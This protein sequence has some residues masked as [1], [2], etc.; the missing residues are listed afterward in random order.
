MVCWPSARLIRPTAGL[1]LTRPWGVL[2]VETLG[3]TGRACART[4]IGTA[5]VLL[6][7]GSGKGAIFGAEPGKDDKEEEFD[8]RVYLDTDEDATG[9]LRAA[10]RARN[11]EPPNWR[12]AIDKYLEC[13]RSYGRT[14]YAQSERLYLP[15][16][17]LVR[18]ELSELPKEGQELYKVLKN[19]EAN[20]AYRRALSATSRRDLEKV[21][22]NYPCL[23]AAPRSLYL[24]G[25]LFRARG[26]AGRA[27]YYWQRLMNDYPDWSECN[28]AAL[29]A[30][31][32]LVAAEAGRHAEC[33]RLLARLKKTSGLA[34]LRVGSREVLVADEVGRRLKAAGQV[35]DPGKAQP[36]FWPSVGGSSAHDGAVSR[37]V[38]AGVRRWQKPL[39]GTAKKP[40][41]RFR[42]SVY[43]RN[44]KPTAAFSQRH[45]VCAGGMIFLAGDSDL[46]AV[47]AM[48]GHI[49]WPAAKNRAPN[50]RLPSTRMTLP[51]IGDGKVFAVL[52]TPQRVNPYNF[53][54]QGTPKS[55]VT[56]RAYALTS[57][58]LRWE[59]G[60]LE[61]AKTREFLRSVDLVSAPVYSGG[62]VFCPAV[63]RGSVNDSYV[64]CF[65]AAD[66]RLVWQTFVC[67]GRPVR[68]GSSYRAYS[69]TEDALPPAVSEGLV[70]FASNL[71]AIGVMDAAS[72]DL[73]WVYLY[74]RAEAQGRRN[75]FG[76]QTTSTVET[77]EPSAPIVRD[78]M[79][80]AAPQD[81]THLFAMELS[82]G[83]MIWRSRRG[84][85]KRLV[86][87]SD[88]KLVCSGGSEIMAFSA[89][90]GK[91]LWRGLL[92][93]TEQGMGLVGDGFVVIPSSTG[94]QR[95]DLETGKL[96]A[97]Y[98]FRTGSTESGN[99]I[100]SGDVLVSAGKT[101]VGGYY[102]W[103]EIVT[104]L[105]KQIVASPQAAAPRAELAEVHFSAEKY[106]QASAYFKESLARVK[107]DESVAGMRLKPVLLRQI[108]ESHSRLAKALEG[109]GKHAEALTDYR[110][111]HSYSLMD[112]VRMNRELMRGHLRF[113]RCK[114][115]LSDWAGAV[116]EYQECIYT[117]ASYDA[118]KGISRYYEEKHSGRAGSSAMAGPFAK[119]QID[120]VIKSK[121]EQAYAQFETQASELLAGAAKAGS[122]K[123]AAAV[124]SRYPNSRSLSPALILM[125]ELYAT[126]GKHPEA[127]ARL[128]EHLSRRSKSPRELEVR[129]RLALS[130]KNQGMTSLTRSIMG[131]MKRSWKGKSFSIAGKEWTVEDFVAKHK[132][133]GK[134]A[135]GGDLL[136]ELGSSLKTAWQVNLGGSVK[137]VP[138]AGPH[139]LTGTA[140]VRQ[141][142]RDV[143]AIDLRTGKRLWTA[144]SLADLSTYSP[145][146]NA[147]AGA[148][149]VAVATG[150]KLVGLGP[151]SGRRLWEHKLVDVKPGNANARFGRTNYQQCLLVSGEGVV[152]AA[153]VVSGRDPKTGRYGHMG[154]LV[155]L[156]EST[157]KLLWGTKMKPVTFGA[158]QL[159]EGT[160][161]A[162]QC[163]RTRNRT[164]VEAY[165][166]GDGTV[167]FKA[168]I[169]GISNV[170]PI[171]MRVRGDRLVFISRSAV[172]CFDTATGKLKWK[173]SISGS[174]QSC[175]VAIDDAR[176]VVASS[177]YG[178]G[179]QSSQLL[180]WSLETGKM[181]WR[182]DPIEG[183]VQQLNHQFRRMGLMA[184]PLSNTA[185]V[186]LTVQAYNRATRKRTNS[187]YV[188]DGKTG[189]LVWRLSAGANTAPS[190][191]L[192]GRKYAA[193]LTNNRGRSERR[194]YDLK[195]GKLVE[196]AAGIFGY[197]T[198]QEG[199]ILQVSSMSLKKL[200]PAKKEGQRR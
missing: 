173:N 195:T 92:S 5:L 27:V 97:S 167:R 170:Y 161:Y 73:L 90:S 109:S 177:R 54:N 16:R 65:D 15:V 72:G 155:V 71:G 85:L 61:D 28:G 96:K 57:G 143:L 172:N 183:Y 70:V 20:L 18:K 174:Q 53:R 193:T 113:A 176:V 14:V 180:C 40:T 153:P 49:V 130:Y 141:K 45:P 60:R 159:A 140:F 148:G 26:Q 134:L 106:R 34:R 165:E 164:I 81:S 108:W 169:A 21:P 127:A 185:H 12:V 69:A 43:S 24:L 2:A 98:R 128:R 186:A 200:K 51:A 66:G 29:L 150:N 184:K 62:Y 87:L 171:P 139:D 182:T 79:I 105:R 48:S 102:S 86:G 63:K 22:A 41:S 194:I 119:A 88:G 154:K 114:E 77:W 137:L 104:K 3:I 144:R 125:S 162:A 83:R 64:L 76:R 89:R 188:Y 166:I 138:K 47:R 179:K 115:G 7:L 67:A 101:V 8:P 111:A 38:D 147:V 23:D 95:F 55:D 39:G 152:I 9:I 110:E 116:A 80:Y 158:V 181:L 44:Y 68:A 117:P 13:A 46:V 126:A 37:V 78:G 36:G 133:E 17:V 157:G 146:P 120:R 135:L 197:L 94:I 56:M 145:L 19:R 178:R 93:G 35:A 121:G 149:V 82:S 6:L 74:D 58:K 142:S 199:S 123:Q 198:Y 118:S 160:V 75:R 175:L 99:L 187:S 84:K 151:T 132:P 191:M 31:S 100:I 32:A 196:K 59:S 50:T 1:Q 136:P 189:K 190:P 129:A 168:E 25:E 103:E 112:P 124:I 131:R 33:A 11:A 163:D 4:L 107:P 52:G 91:R 10:W 122:L 192:I 42:H 30:R 156:D